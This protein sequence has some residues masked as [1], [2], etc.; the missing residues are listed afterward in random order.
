MNPIDEPSP[1]AGPASDAPCL[2]GVPLF[3]LGTVLFPDGVLPLR[4]FEPRYMDRVGEC[5]KSGREFGVCRIVHGTEVGPAADH[6]SVGC[7]AK[8]VHWDMPQLGLLHIRAIGTRRFSVQA[9]RVESNGLIRA[10]IRLHEADAPTAI[11]D[12]LVMVR[13]LLRKLVEE[14]EQHRG[15]AP[16]AVQRPYR[17]DCAG[18]VANRLAEFLPIDP[19]VKQQLMVIDEP[20]ARL[21]LVRRILEDRGIVA[22]PGD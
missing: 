22:K 15:P 19:V 6:E 1:E 20:L 16:V 2:A 4:I 3:P 9:R 13:D 11:P 7:L 21:L 10:D 18:W 17:F 8:I 12:D 5:M 14:L